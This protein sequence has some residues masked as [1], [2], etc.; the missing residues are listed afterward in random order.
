M[1]I[2]YIQRDNRFSTE[3]SDKLPLLRSLWNKCDMPF[4]NSNNACTL[5]KLPLFFFLL[6]IHPS[7]F[8]SKCLFFICV[9]QQ[10][11]KQWELHQSTDII[12]FSLDL[13]FC[14]A[15]RHKTGCACTASLKIRHYHI[16]IYRIRWLNR[17]LKV[18]FQWTDHRLLYK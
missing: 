5:V 4:S 16:F 10:Q 18:V 9:N 12:V 1:T 7:L 13:L 2:G 8:L 6:L 14:L 15:P 17:T 11:Q 3:F